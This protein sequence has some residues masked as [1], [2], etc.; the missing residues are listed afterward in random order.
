M[1]HYQFTLEKGSRKHICPQCT[2]KRFVRYIDL[3]TGHYL[4]SQYGRCDRESS[5]AYHLNPYDDGFAQNGKQTFSNNWQLRNSKLKPEPAFIPVEVLH[6]TLKHYNS[7]IFINNLLRNVQYPFELSVIEKVISLYNLGTVRNSG[8]VCF[9]FIDKNNNIRGIQEKIFD[10][11]NHTD[12]SKKYHTNW[13]HKRLQFTE[14]QY[15]PVPTWL[16]DYLDNGKPASC[17]FGEHLLN[18]YKYNKVALVEAPKTAIYGTLYF[19]FPDNS[20]NMLWLAVYNLSSLKL[21]K[22][23]VL[24]GRIVVLFP[25]LSKNGTAFK[26]WSKK[27]KDMKAKMKNTNFIVSDLLEKLATSAD[28]IKGNDIADFL[29]KLDW[30]KFHN[31]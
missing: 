31:S 10:K 23:K 11:S 30:R 6:S 29:I 24:E 16:T 20:T 27:A 25:D 17:L 12:K 4:P 13:V 5:C 19:G 2:K 28:R 15:K 3:H 8:A 7:N 21:E 26:D 1:N 18:R 22:C 14:Y 9:P